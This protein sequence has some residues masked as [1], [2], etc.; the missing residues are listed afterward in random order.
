[1]RTSTAPRRSRLHLTA[2]SPEPAGRGCGRPSVQA[3]RDVEGHASPTPP[4]AVERSAPVTSA[5]RRG[6]HRFVVPRRRPRHRRE[7]SRF[8]APTP[9]TPHR[10][11][12]R[13]P[14]RRPGAATLGDGTA[15]LVD[16]GD[17][18]D[19]VAVNRLVQPSAKL[20]FAVGDHPGNQSCN[21]SREP[22]TLPLSTRPPRRDR[23]VLGRC[24]GL[25]ASQVYQ[26]EFQLRTT[27]LS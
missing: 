14:A 16:R 22:S 6:P 12:S 26:A 27:A 8:R 1:M 20:R 2:T 13:N 11:R 5:R 9:T 24:Q 19:A 7:R 25:E 23:L 10:C 21:R 18:V 3:V 15:S 4:E 17:R